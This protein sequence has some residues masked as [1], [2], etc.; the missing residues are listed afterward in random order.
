MTRHPNTPSVRSRYAAFYLIGRVLMGLWPVVV[1]GFLP[2]TPALVVYLTGLITQDNVTAT[3]IAG[4]VGVVT[5]DDLTRLLRNQGWNLS[6]GAC[7][8]VRLIEAL[9]LEGWLIIDDVLIP[10]VFAKAIAFCGWDHDHSQHRHVFGMRLVFVVWSNDWLVIPLLFAVWQKDPTKKPRKKRRKKTE[11]GAKGKSKS[12]A[13]KQTKVARKRRRRRK[14]T[15]RSKIVRLPNGVRFR[16][17]NELARAMVWKLRRRGLKTDYV[18]FDNWYASDDNL[19]L[20]ER[21]K[22]HWVTRSKHNLKVE[23]EGNLMAVSQVAA[24]VKKPCYHYYKALGARARSFR[25]K[26]DGRILLLVVIKDDRSQEGGRTKY[27]L[28]SDLSLTTCEVVK[29]Y[30]KRWPIEVFFRDCKQLLGL[31]ECEARNA[32]AIIS[33]IALVCVAYTLLQLFKPASQRPR[34]SV[35]VIKHELTPLVMLFGKHSG[36]VAH[37]QSP[38]G[39]LLKVDL[40]HFLNPIRTRLPQLVIPKLLVFS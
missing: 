32:Q 20:F 39:Q 10:K 5:H 23:Y 14:S 11:R 16:T 2:L 3:A 21:L 8:S 15:R 6:V 1:R 27:L 33:H 36:L 40:E 13:G 29:W 4:Q 19:R 7:L 28:T 30:R 9:G 35:C 12:A 25:V 38:D 24:T 17:K 37:R 26:R 18:L 34:P 31:C 22:L